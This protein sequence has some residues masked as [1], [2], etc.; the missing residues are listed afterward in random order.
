M[1]VLCPNH[2]DEAR[3]MK[4]AEQRRLK[5]H[6][7]NIEHGLAGGQLKVEHEVPRMTVGDSVGLI[8][9]GPLVEI[10]G[11]VLLQL[12]LSPE[13]ALLISATL[14]DKDDR[15]LVRIN[16][17]AWEAEDPLPWD[18]DFGYQQLTVRSGHGQIALSIDTRGDDVAVRGKLWRHGQEIQLTNSGVRWPSGGGLSDLS[19]EGGMIR[20]KSEEDAVELGPQRRMPARTREDRIGRN[21]PCWCGS[22]VKY[23]KCHGR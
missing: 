11:E 14:F 19:L 15:L 6:P 4:E 2:H 3:V 7:H 22:G 21:D 17:N 18:L 10:D 20:R 9:A 16:E 13:K 5:G 12:G 23:K 8:G 1:M